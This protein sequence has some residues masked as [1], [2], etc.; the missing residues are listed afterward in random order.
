MGTSHDDDDD[1]EI[2]SDRSTRRAVSALTAKDRSI[3][4]ARRRTWNASSGSARGAASGSGVAM[5][6]GSGRARGDV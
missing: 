4:D 2:I 6:R 3:R 5:T 1:D